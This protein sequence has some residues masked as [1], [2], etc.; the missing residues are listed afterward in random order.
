MLRGVELEG[1]TARVHIA[2]TVPGC[3]MKA[4]IAHDV[5][6]ALGA[7]EGIDG[8]EV[9][10]EAMNAEQRG[11]LISGLRAGTNGGGEVPA[12]FTEGT[13]VIAIASGKGG[14]G[15]STLAVNLACAMAQRGQ[16]VGLIDAD[17][18]GFSVPRMLGITATPNAVD[19]LLFPAE[20]HGV[21]VMSVGLFAEQQTPVVWRG[22]LLHKA[23]RQFIADVHWGELDVLICDLPPGTG[24]VPISIGAM[25]PTAGVV[26]VTTPQDSVAD[27]AE[28]AGRMAQ[29]AHLRVSGVIENMSSF[30]CPCCGEESPL[31]G[32]GGGEKLARALDAP[33]LAQVPFSPGVGASAD[34][35][36]PLVLTDPDAPGSREIFH[37]ADRLLDQVP[38]SAQLP[39]YHAAAGEVHS[40]GVRR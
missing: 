3:P 6:T 2:L 19:G 21:K 36:T 7:V 22:P 25:L 24:D 1:S 40:E 31:F 15:K 9:H 11:A 30:V 34:S 27:V 23:M 26:V 5:A 20:A 18:W 38:P 33:L 13:T 14:V 29:H 4:R 16:R 8:V 28:R 17:V 37:A 12:L 39:M 32:T 35:G 10:F